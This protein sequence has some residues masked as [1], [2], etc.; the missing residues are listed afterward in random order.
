MIVLDARRLEKSKNKSMNDPLQP[1]NIIDG[2]HLGEARDVA[3]SNSKVVN[4]KFV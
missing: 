1:K 2:C 4:V 3:V